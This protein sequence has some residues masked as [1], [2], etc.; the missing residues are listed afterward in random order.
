MH[1]S[2]FGM[3]AIASALA[4][5]GGWLAGCGNST[6]SSGAPAGHG[7]TGGSSTGGTTAS[8]SGGATSAS[9]PAGAGGPTTTP[10]SG[11]SVGQ[12]GGTAAP[13]SGG[14]D[15]GAAGGGPASGGPGGS[16]TSSAAGGGSSLPSS[17][18]GGTGTALGGTDPGTDEDGDFTIMP[19]YAGTVQVTNVP[20]STK[21]QFTMQ[22]SASKVYPGTGTR[23]IT[24]YIPK[25]Y[26]DGAEA[27]FIIITDGNAPATGSPEIVTAAEN[28]YPDTDPTTAIPP[29]VFVFVPPGNNRSVEYDTVS[30]AFSTFIDTE[31]LPLVATNAD[32][33]AAYPNFKL[34]ANPDGRAAYG[35]SSGSPAAMGLAWFADF[36]R[37][38]SYSG[39]F[40]DLQ[41]TA[42]HPLGAW[43]YPAMILASPP[44]P[45][46]IF[47]EVGEMD[48]GYTATADSHRNWVIGNQ[49][50]A[51]A[52]KMQGYHYRFLYAMG[53]GHCDGSVKSKTYAQTLNWVWRGYTPN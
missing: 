17:A 34:T 42:D 26:V 48:N 33:K 1:R 39:T 5:S 24:V 29:L 19:P 28:H 41:M 10:S 15:V 31:V 21:Y 6:T 49:N 23:P 12:T 35:C 52:L 20:H 2:G 53:A 16:T 36:H 25:Q 32:I 46:R 40:V 9:G 47:L 11:G 8:G 14:A 3:V 38:V 50:M 18:G 13:G 30:D 4:C 51:A 43:E 22:N 27:P 45:L 7:A 37:V 44:R